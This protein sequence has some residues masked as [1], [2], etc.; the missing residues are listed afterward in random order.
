MPARAIGVAWQPD[1]ILLDVLV[2]GLD[3]VEC[4]RRLKQDPATLYIPIK[5][6][7]PPDETGGRLRGLE[8]GPTTF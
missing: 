7:T 6:V 5:M 3:G 1:F 4:C 8:A 2:P